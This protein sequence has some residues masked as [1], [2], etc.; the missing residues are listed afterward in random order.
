MGAVNNTVIFF[1][2]A[3]D[4][5]SYAL[6][7]LTSSA[8]MRL[9]FHPLIPWQSATFS[10]TRGSISSL[11]F[12]DSIYFVEDL[13]FCNYP[14]H[15]FFSTRIRTIALSIAGS[16]RTPNHQTLFPLGVSIS[17][18]SS[19]GAETLLS[20]SDCLFSNYWHWNEIVLSGT[21][22]MMSKLQSFSQAE[23]VVG[24]TGAAF[25]NVLYWTR[26]RSYRIIPLR[27]VYPRLVSGALDL[28]VCTLFGCR[29]PPYFCG[30]LWADLQ[31]ASTTEH[32][33][34]SILRSILISMT[35][36]SS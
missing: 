18:G 21:Y 9:F 8:T 23:V 6:P 26:I 29:W 16:R 30:E 28:Y 34:N 19:R 32:S 14:W 35:S 11:Q 5:S 22:S 31:H 25:A 27:M 15:I 10:I 33:Q 24:C 4:G 2:I 1:W 20:D 17:R 3:C 13:I 36:C 7:A 12:A